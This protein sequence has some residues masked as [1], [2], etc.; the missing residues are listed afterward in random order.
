MIIELNKSNSENLTKT[1][2]EII[3]FIN[4][5]ESIL[6]ELSIVEIAHET[7]S[8]PATV[9]RAIR[10][11]G[12]NGF[13]EL[14]Y[15]LTVKDEND[16][17]QN[18]GDIINKSFI[19]A[20][21]VIEQISLTTLINIIKTINKSSKIYILARGLTEYVAKEFSLKLQLLDFNVV[22]INDPNIMKIKS[23]SIKKDELII[24]FSLN[25]N[26]VE[27]VESAQNANLVGAKVITC[28]CSESAKLIKYSDLYIVGY[29]HEH[30]SISEYE[31]SSRLPLYII[32]RII[33]DYMVRY[34]NSEN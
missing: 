28:C 29:K 13:N 15:R 11:C 14:R 23:K 19:E 8:S 7:Y 27:L 6:P 21:R 24:I 9:S 31:V 33:I 34:N 2:L 32:S 18:M 20:Q 30:I 4:E 3:K 22:F 26:T 5:N 12:L 10:K 1:E 16:D 17:I 25:G